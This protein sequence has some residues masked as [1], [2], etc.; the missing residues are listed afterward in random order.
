MTS[1]IVSNRFRY[2]KRILQ[3]LATPP[4]YTACVLLPK[5]NS[6]T[7]PKIQESPK[8][9][10]FF[11]GALGA[12]DGTHIRCTSSAA[13]RD[14]SRNRKGMLTQNCLAACTFD[15]RFIYFLSGW[16]GSS[17]DSTL[18][19]DSRRVD[20]YIPPGRYYLADAGF[21][22]SDALLVPYRSVRYHLFELDR[23]KEA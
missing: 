13:D 9:Y 17:H 12:I 5:S 16:E 1:L 19:Y 8:F 23:A 7:P 21:A 3:A 18:F 15:L 20:F 22:S 10:P 6:P 4:F 2:F 11:E 14:A